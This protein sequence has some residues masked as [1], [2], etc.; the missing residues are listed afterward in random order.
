VTH[1]IQSKIEVDLFDCTECGSYVALTAN[2]EHALR[3]TH[4]T[5][6]CPNGHSQYFPSKTDAEKLR[7]ALHAADIEKSRLAKAVREAEQIANDAA[8]RQTIAER[9][10]ARLKK[11]ASAGVCPCCNRTFVQLARHMKTKHPHAIDNAVNK[12]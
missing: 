3:A 10:T 1:T 9:E 11:R 8:Y 6:Y 7:E 5:F 4:K 12:P 2:H